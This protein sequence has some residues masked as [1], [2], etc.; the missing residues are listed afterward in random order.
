MEIFVAPAYGETKEVS[1]AI[2]AKLLRSYDLYVDLEG[3]LSVNGGGRITTELPKLNTVEQ[4]I[5]DQLGST[6][7]TMRYAYA[8]WQEVK[9]TPNEEDHHKVR[10]DND[11]ARWQTIK[12]FVDRLFWDQPLKLAAVR[13]AAGI[14]WNKDYR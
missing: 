3:T 14:D 1:P 2:A 13:I 11:A 12:D 9:D 10:A 6:F 7:A 5:A 4:R 8:V